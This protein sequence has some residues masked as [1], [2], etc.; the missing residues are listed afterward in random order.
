MNLLS[1]III[2]PLLA[3]AAILAMPKD[4]KPLYYMTALA[5]SAIQLVLS[6][7]CCFTYGEAKTAEGPA[8]LEKYDWITMKLG[9]MGTLSID[10]HVG[11]D[12]LN[13]SLILLSA[14]IMFFGT[15]ASK[16]IEK[17]AK[18]YFA[19][20]MLLSAS[21]AGCFVSLD[22]FLFYLFFEFMLLP[23]YF[24][25]GMWGGPRR[26]Y[27]AIK[28][29][30]Y[31]LFGSVLILISMIALYTSVIDPASTAV[32]LGLA[33]N[34][35]AVS[36]EV[37]STVQNQLAQGSI[38]AE[39]LVRTFDLNY[40]TD[41][42]NY[43]PDSLLAP[44]SQKVIWGLSLRAWAFLLILVGFA[45]KLPTVPFHT[46]LPDAHVEAPTAISVILAGILLKIGGYGLLRTGIAI[47]PDGAIDFA[48]LMGLF[49]VISILYG[50]MNALAQKD[51]KSLVAYSSVSHMGFVL[52]G[53]ASLTTEG[54]QGAVYQMF[55][56]GII[57]A[58]LFL[59]AGVLYERTNDRRIDNFSGLAKSMP[60]YTTVVIA[61]FF[62]SLGLPGFSG[63]IAELLVFLGA[64]GS[65]S[66]NGL[67]PRWMAIAA[68]GGLIIGAA[69]YLWTLQRMFFGKYAVKAEHDPAKMTDL[70]L[71]ERLIMYPL[72]ALTILFGIFPNLIFKMTDADVSALVQRVAEWL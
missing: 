63:F 71:H 54:V 2:T 37:I 66:V 41:K 57:A 64:F 67:L 38:K 34:A 6:L 28:F 65:A 60:K 32:K 62:A 53:L 39:Q 51:L 61:G 31:T 21:I 8:F 35:S 44:L 3:G 9:Q 12:G 14:I 17:K 46:W 7:F 4:R 70:S 45:I 20:L 69:Y 49:G 24:L 27:A 1:W 29:F 23:M 58:L 33:E 43:I 19:L 15:M 16:N 56:H 25:I 55:S 59:I 68:V 40:M 22:F 26:E 52:L 13:I 36:T 72:C 30:L 50:G 18:G 47:F 48:W 11:A 10:Y 42:G 5:A